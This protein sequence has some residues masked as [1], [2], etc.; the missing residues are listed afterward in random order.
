[1]MSKIIVMLALAFATLASSA[2]AEWKW[3]HFGADPYATSREA[4]MKTREIAFAKLGLPAEAVAVA[5]QATTKPSEP[6]KLTNGDRLGAMISKG[7][8]VHRDVLVDFKNP[9]QRGME[10]V[11]KAEKW[12]VTSEGKIY[13]ILLPEVCNNWSVTTAQAPVAQQT[14]APASVV[15]ACPNGYTI[16]ANAWS[17]KS[18][19]GLRKEAEG[20]IAAANA[21]ESDGGKSLTAYQGPSVSRIGAR[22]RTEVKD[23]AQI[24]GN[25]LQVRYLDP[26][27]AKVVRELGTMTL[28]QGVGTLRFPDDPRE[29]VVETVWPREF[30]SPTMSGGERR[31]R[32][33]PSE[34]GKFC[35][36]NAHGISLP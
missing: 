31:L 12:V 2:H 6:T 30:V 14:T 18:L 27:T 15:G 11:A 3:Q 22:L 29:Y 19:G 10:F 4:A 21:R 5:M 26:Q 17:L 28:I 1:M 34:W 36:M 9:S 32:I 24:S 8:I 33:F 23:R 16:I 7:S 35:S 13:T 20:L 25:V